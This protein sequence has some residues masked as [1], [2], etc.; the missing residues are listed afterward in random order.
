MQA[1]RAKESRKRKNQKQRVESRN[2]R[3]LFSDFSISVF[4]LGLVDHGHG[5]TE[6]RKAESR[7]SHQD[8]S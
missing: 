8:K 3:F 7:N 1:S 6:M 5:R 4:V 2:S